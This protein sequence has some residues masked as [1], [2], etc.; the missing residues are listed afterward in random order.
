MAKID[1]I[2]LLAREYEATDIYMTAGMPLQYRVNGKLL[3]APIQPSEKEVEDTIYEILNQKKRK[4]FEEGADVSLSFKN[5]DG[6]R[7]RIHV[8]RQ[9]K[10][11]AAVIH[12]LCPKI[13]GLEEK[14]IFPQI[15]ELLEEE[16]GLI[17][18]AGKGGSGRTTMAVSMLEYLNTTS[19]RHI[20]TLEN[21]VEYIFQGKKCLIHQR[22]IGRDADSMVQALKSAAHEVC[23]VI[24]V[25]EIP[26]FECLREIMKLVEAGNVVIAVVDVAEAKRVQRSLVNLCPEEYRSAIKSQLE[27]YVKGII[28]QKIID[29]PEEGES[30]ILSEFLFE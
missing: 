27:E 16:E 11:I 9:R 26:D 17:L 4:A 21:P 19:Q 5:Q 18:I 14:E 30:K 23:D 10:R 25:T 12:L 2:L 7:Q 28:Q 1:E 15:K 29:S 13:P 6:I 20:L 22:E 24:Y 3:R 8:F